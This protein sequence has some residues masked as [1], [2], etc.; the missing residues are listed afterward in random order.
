MIEEK[1]VA[2]AMTSAAKIAEATVKKVWSILDA[3]AEKKPASEHLSPKA[4]QAIQGIADA[5]GQ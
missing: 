3:A 4:I 1:I 5:G 2:D